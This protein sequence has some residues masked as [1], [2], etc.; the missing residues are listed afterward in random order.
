MNICFFHQ[1]HFPPK[2][3]VPLAE[4]SYKVA[5]LQNQKRLQNRSHKTSGNKLVVHKRS[6]SLKKNMMDY[7]HISFIE[8]LQKMHKNIEGFMRNK[9]NVKFI[10]KRKKVT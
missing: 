1:K 3:Y 10:K 2:G 9:S 4:K 5:Y 7:E 6:E 8:D